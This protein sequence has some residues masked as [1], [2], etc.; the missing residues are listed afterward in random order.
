MELRTLLVQVL[1]SFSL[2]M[3]G[4]REI[5]QADGGGGLQRTL[6][7]LSDPAP[8]VRVAACAMLAALSSFPDSRLPCGADGDAML[9]ALVRVFLDDSEPAVAHAA[10]P[11]LQQL[12]N[13]Q[14]RLDKDTLTKLVAVMDE[15]ARAVASSG[16]ADRAATTRLRT[17]LQV[18]WNSALLSTQKDAAISVGMV[19]CL[20]PLLADASEQ[21]T[22]RLAAGL[23]AALA[24]AHS[25]KLAL[26]AQAGAVSHA[27]KLALDRRSAGASALGAAVRDNA[28]ALIRNF[29]E[30]ARGL[31]AVGAALLPEPDALLAVL[32]PDRTA[33]ILAPRL[34]ALASDPSSPLAQA[35]E[36]LDTMRALM[37]LLKTGAGSGSAAADDSDGAGSFST[38]PAA[39]LAMVSGS[40]AGSA[41]AGRAAAWRIQDVVPTLHA[42]THYAPPAADSSAAAAEQAATVKTLAGRALLLLCTEEPEA[43]LQLEG[44]GAR[45][46]PERAAQE[47]IFALVQGRAE[48]AAQKA[49][50]E[51]AALEL[52]A[53][54]REEEA[55][56]LAICARAFHRSHFSC[57]AILHFAQPHSSQMS[58]SSSSGYASSEAF[59][60]ASRARPGTV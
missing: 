53:R 52:E 10:L 11:A 9:R 31:H 5:L 38:A 50:A 16:G 15:S 43:R 58:S 17:A 25:G 47:E 32:G 59:R 57:F 40:A 19:E 7:L 49:A 13:W 48:A 33:Q 22:V 55:A 42:L 21:E 26:L 45:L 36:A 2:L 60:K 8:P 6:R 20:V 1:R 24:V 44:I 34:A 46:G 14:P 3:R 4:R 56:R 51:L 18:A 39:L 35:H 12:T 30:E 28:I 27:C 37:A 29:A 54:L 41:A 23:L